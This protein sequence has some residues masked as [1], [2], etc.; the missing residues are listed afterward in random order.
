MA[1]PGRLLVLE[2]PK[3]VSVRSSELPRALA[4]LIRSEKA[5]KKKGGMNDGIEKTQESI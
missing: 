2:P 1:L 4:R 3:G 5:T